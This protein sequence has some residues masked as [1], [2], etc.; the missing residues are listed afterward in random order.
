MDVSD[1]NDPQTYLNKAD[2]WS[3][4]AGRKYD[5]FLTIQN[6]GIKE[7]Q[8][9]GISVTHSQYLGIGVTPGTSQ[10]GISLPLSALDFIV[11]PQG[12]S[13]NPGT[14]TV[15]FEYQA[16]NFVSPLGGKCHTC[17]VATL[18]QNG[19]PVAGPQVQQ[20]SD[21]WAA[22]VVGSSSC[23]AT[24]VIIVDTA[25]AIKPGDTVHLTLEEDVKSGLSWKPLLGTGSVPPANAP[26]D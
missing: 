19:Q 11:P 23:A 13:G 5:V 18:T 20:N 7:Q 25:L 24:F 12:P 10:T 8:Q 17:F 15:Y 9:V 3:L 21:T 2:A 1:P 22:N 26:L 14:T 6:T 4:Q 16:P